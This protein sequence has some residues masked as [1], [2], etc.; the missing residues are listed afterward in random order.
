MSTQTSHAVLKTTSLKP[1]WWPLAMVNQISPRD[2]QCRMACRSSQFFFSPHFINYYPLLCTSDLSQILRNWKSQQACRVL[3]GMCLI[4]KTL[5]LV[6]VW[7]PLGTGPMTTKALATSDTFGHLFSPLPLFC[8]YLFTLHFL[9]LFRVQAPLVFSVDRKS[10]LLLNFCSLLLP[11]FSS[12]RPTLI[13]LILFVRS[14]VRMA[15]LSREYIHNSSDGAVQH[16]FFCLCVMFRAPPLKLPLP[17]LCRSGSKNPPQD[18]IP[19]WGG[20]IEPLLTAG[21]EPL[22]NKSTSNLALRPYIAITRICVRKE[23]HYGANVSLLF[24]F[25]SAR[26]DRTQ[27]RVWKLCS[28]G[29]WRYTGH[30]LIH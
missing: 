2:V 23:F 6:L 9:V 29:N 1:S 8:W 12:S 17:V 13:S 20:E 18:G 26:W 4:I 3:T 7:P 15:N 30:S 25:S 27:L 5:S 21:H 11:L 24:Y 22:K 10:T 14:L 19:G 16:H 28:N